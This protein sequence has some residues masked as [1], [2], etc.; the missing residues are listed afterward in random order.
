M[1]ENKPHLNKE[2]LEKL[3]E[4]GAYLREC[5]TKQF[6]GL[7]EVAAR[8]RIQARLLNAIEEGKPEQLPEPVY[9]QGFIKRF[10]EELGLN[11]AEFA[12]EFPTGFSLQ[13]AKPTWKYIRP[14]QLRPFHLYLLYVLLVMGAVRGLSDV[15]NRSALQGVEVEDNPSNTQELSIPS[16]AQQQNPKLL[17][18]GNQ[19]VLG[20]HS[21][22]N[23]KPVQVGVTL[24]AQSWIRV[25][26]DGK[27]EFEGVLPEGTQRTWVADQKLVVKAG[28]AGGVLVE[29]NDQSAKQMGAPG[30]VEEVTFAAN[31]RL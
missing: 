28:N 6:L 21:S 11:G 26:V 7:D 8:T 29:F 30:E 19:A 20:T 24:K 17:S 16:Y 9:I 18:P 27:T 23:N 4:L 31:S 15:V 3:K 2:Q 22:P 5:R 10:A 13:F 25:V 1:K 12:R 14:A